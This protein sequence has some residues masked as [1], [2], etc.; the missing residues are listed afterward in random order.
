MATRRVPLNLGT[1]VTLNAAGSG[2]ARIGPDSSRGPAV[3]IIDGVILTN[4]R[5][6]QAPIPRVQVYVDSVSPANRQGLSYDG[7]FAQGKCDIR[8]TRGQQVLAVWDAGQSGDICEFTVTGWKE[9]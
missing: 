1:T 9:Q 3:W 4:G 2:T 8:L 6:G 7:S 5:P